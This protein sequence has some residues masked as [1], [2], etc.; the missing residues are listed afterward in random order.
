MMESSHILI[1]VVKSIGAFLGG[2]QLYLAALPEV[3]CPYPGYCIGAFPTRARL[4]AFCHE[5]LLIISR[6]IIAIED[7]AGACHAFSIG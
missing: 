7:P 2:A 4:L 3:N 1:A 5:I 6:R